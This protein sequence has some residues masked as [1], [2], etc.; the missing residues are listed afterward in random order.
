MEGSGGAA[1]RGTRGGPLAALGAALLVGA[2][3]VPGPC[4]SATIAGA[5]ITNLAEITWTNDWGMTITGAQYTE[6]TATAYAVAI[7]FTADK[8]QE[9]SGMPGEPLRYRIV[10][11]NVSGG[12]VTALTVVD[13]V[14]PVLAEATA[15]Q[16]AGFGPPGVAAAAGGTLYVWTGG[17]LAMRPS[18]AFT[19]TITG[20][21]GYVCAPTAVNNTAMVFGPGRSGTEYVLTPGVGLTAMPPALAITAGKEQFPAAPYIGQAVTYRIVVA[22]TGAATIENLVVVDTVS[23]MV[24]GASAAGPPGF[25]VTGP[26]DVAGGTR[27]VWSGSGLALSPGAS[28]TF[29][30]TGTVGVVD[31][32]T[33]MSN[34]ALVGAASGCAQATVRTDPVGSVVLPPV[35]VTVVKAQVPL[36]PGMGEVIAYQI[37]VTNT[38]AATVA[39]L[40]VVDTLSPAVA[41]VTAGQPA[42]FGAP[43]VEEVGGGTR[44]VWSAAGLSFP[45]GA[46][47]SFTVTGTV[48]FLCAPLLLTNTAFVVCANPGGE[49]R[50]LS[51]PV[52]HTVA[53]P[54]LDIAAV[55][56][57]SPS[58]LLIGE[59]VVYRV[60]I[61]NTGGA[62]IDDLTVVGTIP[63]VVVSPAA[64]QP[65]GFGVPVP[66]SV[67]GGT[68]YAWSAA[69]L[70]MLPGTSLT[71]TVTGRVGAVCIETAV[72]A[73]AYVIA[74]TPCG[75]T[76]AFTNHVS[77]TLPPPTLGLDVVK[78]QVPADPGAG[79]PVTYRIVVT[80]EGTATI[81]D[82]L[83]VDTL[84]PALV[85]LATD[86][87]AGIAAATVTAAPPFGTRIVWEQGGVSLGPGAGFTFTITGAVTGAICG[88]VRA[89][90]T[91]YFR[92]G[93]GCGV[94][95]GVTG[96][97][98]FELD[99]PS[100]AVVKG[101]VPATPAMGAPVTYWIVVSNDGGITLDDIVVV[102]TVAPEI[103]AVT[104]GQPAGFGPPAVMSAGG[105]GTRYVWTAAASDL[106]APGASFTFTISGT[107]GMVATTTTV[108]NGAVASGRNAG[109]SVPVSAV[110]PAVHF[111]IGLADLESSLVLEPTAPVLGE[112]LTLRFTVAN[113]GGGDA[114][115]VV[116]ALDV[117]AGA[118]RVVRQSGPTPAGPVTIGPGGQRTFVWSYD[119]TGAGPVAFTCSAAGTDSATGVPLAA[120]S[121]AGVTAVA[122]ASLI[123]SLGAGQLFLLSGQA[124]V[125]TAN[126]T[127]TGGAAAT[128]I[129]ASLWHSSGTGGAVVVGPAPAGIAVLLPGETVVFS[130]TA[131]GA[132]SGLI[133]WS[134]S[135]GADGGVVS[136]VAES[137]VVTV[138]T[139]KP[140]PLNAGISPG[141]ARVLGGKRGPVRPDLGEV[142]RVQVWPTGAGEVVVAVVDGRGFLLREVVQE[143]AGG[144]PEF[145]VWDCRNRSGALVPL[146]IYRLFVEGPGVARAGPLVVLVER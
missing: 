80:N 116:P 76:R 1:G 70:N 4:S 12:T 142:A 69:G 126:V 28:L 37:V 100:I 61:T 114:V 30:V 51:N 130:W 97:V 27:Y 95:E 133:S 146:G 40:T 29:T 77:F 99:G 111:V 39:E 73:T 137:P 55:M 72:A 139:L 96:P 86:E 53:V 52:G 120:S 48:G 71:F 91:A 23:P 135:V 132:A 41:V 94:I 25:S 118:S 38:G 18:E 101:Q 63:P 141:S 93:A 121:S 33:F 50:A 88:S 89:S 113:A 60:V 19:F 119:V 82:L 54:E 8:Q 64:H 74:G 32:P 138:K 43:T 81:T 106:L 31:V 144:S 65:P 16:P 124:A 56:E 44:Y 112:V 6:T 68:R 109:C 128:N 67:S 84:P 145:V 103:A 58:A 47:L 108:F 92:A 122:P 125:L 3:C 83:V 143:T 78:A 102:D 59:P 75:T 5:V 136:N 134:V 17:G 127:N 34:T 14:S 62:T 129:T 35:H 115:G 79:A 104:T 117:N 46:S 9:S 107:V 49:M 131:T 13:T 26:A 2:S 21:V 10:V 85:G 45:P 42:G 20:R 105:S 98:G 57:Q 110:S 140:D 36:S 90:S 11:T 22:N 66:A 24:V 87:P 7:S 123:V 15:D